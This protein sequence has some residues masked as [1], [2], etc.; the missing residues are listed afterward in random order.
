[1]CVLVQ[2]ADNRRWMRVKQQWQA[3]G[4]S[5]TTVDPGEKVIVWIDSR[6]EQGWTYVEAP[7]GSNSA[8]GWLPDFCLEWNAD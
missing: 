5:Q 4:E 2:L 1:M 3:I 8:P 6:T 7:E